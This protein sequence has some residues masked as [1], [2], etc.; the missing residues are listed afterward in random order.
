MRL[1]HC[2]WIGFEEPGFA[3]RCLSRL[4]LELLGS[5][6]HTHTA[7]SAQNTHVDNRVYTL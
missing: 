1:M 3:L 2:K 4:E 6:S 7:V 5:G